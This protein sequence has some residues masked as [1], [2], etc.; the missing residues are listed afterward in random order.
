M[1]RCQYVPVS[2]HIQ[3]SAEQQKTLI[4]S[5][6]E[7]KGL[8]SLST[9][10]YKHC[11]HSTYDS[12][13]YVFAILHFSSYVSNS[14][15]AFQHKSTKGTQVHYIKPGIHLP[16]KLQIGMGV[17]SDICCSFS[18]GPSMKVCMSTP[19]DLPLVLVTVSSPRSLLI[20][21]VMDTVKE[22]QRRWKDKVEQMNDEGLVKN[23][24]EEEVME[25]R[26]RG[27]PKK[28]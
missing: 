10:V 5:T 14:C 27:R 13:C 1:S 23:V 26:L 19:V 8:M 11:I 17:F 4:I 25:N 28:R 24:Y 9:T 21:A 2:D 12:I 20:A 7:G 15:E 6:S 16:I 22:K 3:M 18:L